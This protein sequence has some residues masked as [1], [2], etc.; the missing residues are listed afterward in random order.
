LGGEMD[1]R[2]LREFGRKE[3]AEEPLLLACPS[4]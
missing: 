4:V 2:A 3:L 1:K